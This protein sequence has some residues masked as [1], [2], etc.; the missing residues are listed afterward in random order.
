M[1]YETAW[2]VEAARPASF[3]CR[4]TVAQRHCPVALDRSVGY[5]AKMLSRTASAGIPL[6]SL[7]CATV[8]TVAVTHAAV[9]A[10]DEGL[11]SGLRRTLFGEHHA[12][13]GTLIVLTAVGLV[14][15]VIRSRRA[16]AMPPAPSGLTL[17]LVF[18]GLVLLS[19]AGLLVAENL[20]TLHGDHVHAPVGLGPLRDLLTPGGITA[21]IGSTLV[22]ATFGLPALAPEPGS[23]QSVL[24]ESYASLA[25]DTYGATFEHEDWAATFFRSVIGWLPMDPTKDPLRI[26]ECGVGSGYWLSLLGSAP[27]TRSVEL[28]GFDLSHD[29]VAQARTRLGRKQVPADVWVGDVLDDR[30]YEYEGGA[31]HDLLFAYDV[32]QQLPSGLQATALTTMLRHVAPGGWLVVFDHDAASSY[33]RTMGAR[34][35]LRRHFGVPLVPRHY[36]YT[37]Y[38]S[39]RRLRAELVRSDAA[40]IGILTEPQDRHSAL[41]VQRSA[42]SRRAA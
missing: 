31:E 10:Q 5:I 32:I 1:P 14:V 4:R 17:A 34:K 38:P 27:I 25:A 19:A 26:L 23:Y 22:I 28:R 11:V 42:R 30:A 9:W 3:V 41:V 2:L 24:R 6:L 37:T 39:I 20:E 12:Y 8:L 15:L 18:G 7:L 16:F 36:L 13:W 35:W 33:G 29:M 40:G 21:L